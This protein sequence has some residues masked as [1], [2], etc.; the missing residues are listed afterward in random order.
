MLAIIKDIALIYNFQ[1]IKQL[2]ERIT[3]LSTFEPS[4]LIGLLGARNI[5][6]IILKGLSLVQ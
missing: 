4:P 6:L 1:T 5:C 3:T 2:K